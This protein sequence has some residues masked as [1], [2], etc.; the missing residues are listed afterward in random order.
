MSD[1]GEQNLEQTADVGA[2]RVAR[3]YA[4]ALLNAAQKRGQAEA[5]LEE[6]DSL[7]RDVFKAN[8]ELETFLSATAVGR[9]RRAQVI[10]K[11]FE[12]RGSETFVSFMLVLNE[13]ERLEL[14]RPILGAYRELLDERARRVRVQVSSVTPLNEAQQAGLEKQLRDS[15]HLE[16]ILEMKTDPDLIGGIVI[17]VGDWLY[18]GSLRTKLQTI[19]NQIIASSS[20]EIQSR[21][22]RFSTAN[23]D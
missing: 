8:P 2:Q 16:P 14:L 1:N 12:G 13:H 10:R 15:L 22:D 19:R 3:V 21:R 20:H 23:G 7:V 4:E 11:A 18:D 17:R 9:K 6:L 5:V